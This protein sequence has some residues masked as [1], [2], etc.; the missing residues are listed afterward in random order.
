MEGFE[1]KIKSSET[2]SA[3]IS[4]SY[5]YLWELW[6]RGWTERNVIVNGLSLR[7]T[8]GHVII[9]SVASPA[10]DNILEW[11]PQLLIALSDFS[12]LPVLS[13]TA[14]CS[15]NDVIAHKKTIIIHKKTRP[16]PIAFQ[17]I[18]SARKFFISLFSLCFIIGCGCWDG[19][20]FYSPFRE[21]Q[22]RAHSFWYFGAPYTQIIVERP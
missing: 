6:E 1:E 9:V 3:I 7:K 19:I 5:H 13:H 11:I 8:S 14:P 17:D 12:H 2:Y 22:Y 20:K 18:S 16:R 4:S 15:G 10:T 21:H